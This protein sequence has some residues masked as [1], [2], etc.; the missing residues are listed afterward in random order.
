MHSVLQVVLLSVLVDPATYVGNVYGTTRPNADV[1]VRDGADFVRT[2]TAGAGGQFLINNI[3]A[4]Y[5]GRDYT[6]ASGGVEITARVLPGAAMA[7]EVDLVKGTSRYRHERGEPLPSK[8]TDSV[9]AAAGG[10]GAPLFFSIFATR[11]GLVGGT[12]ANGHVIVPNDHFVA[13]PSRRALATNFGHEREVRLTYRGLTTVVPV[14][15]VG[16]WNTHDDYWNPPA[17][18]ETFKDLRRGLPESEA[19]FYSAYNGGRDERGRTVK[20]PAGIDLADGTFWFDLGLINNDR[21]T[22][23]YLWVDSTGPVTT[24]VT[25]STHDGVFVVDARISDDSS[26]AAAEMFVDAIGQSGSGIPL[27]PV[28]GA[29]DSTTENVHGLVGALAPGTHVI[30]I[31][32]RDVY[33]N[34]GEV[35]AATVS[36]AGDGTRRRAVRHR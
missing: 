2:A 20:N 27:S 9:R 15:D 16:P 11:E 12:T 10:N 30:Y 13:L 28:D 19:A 24:E 5:D 32:A 29:F 4:P 7:L 6:I 34:W 23:E 26:I 8:P 31:H 36:A 17:I 33:E 1:T 25:P 35:S 3:P 14:W 18:R 22:V 21:V